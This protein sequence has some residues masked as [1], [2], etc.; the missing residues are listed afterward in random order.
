MHINIW[1]FSGVYES[2]EFFKELPHTW[3]DMKDLAGTNCYCDE[4]AKNVIREKI[5]RISLSPAGSDTV[6]FTDS[7]N[8][9]YMSLLLQEQIAEDYV[10]CLW[11]NHPD[12]QEAA[13][14]GIT[15]CGGWVKEALDTLPH[16]K[17]V[18]IMGVEEELVEELKPLD[19]RV[20]VIRSWNPDMGDEKVKPADISKYIAEANENLPVYITVD[21]DVMNIE[22]TACNWSQGVTVFAQ[23]ASEIQPQLNDK[24]ILGIDAC[25]ECDI[26]DAESLNEMNDRFNKKFIGILA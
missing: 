23:L 24:R 14:G 15:S 1:N 25:G 6:H 5:K 10:L 9:H 19:D 18:L 20:T 26:S 12:L 11:D 13:F 8:Y 17:Q 2:Q 4:E 16:L 3:I 21:K 7:G 22:E